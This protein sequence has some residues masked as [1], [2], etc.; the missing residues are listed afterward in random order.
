ML[1]PS[2]PAVSGDFGTVSS[3]QTD[4]LD[5]SSHLQY[6]TPASVNVWPW[7]SSSS[8]AQLETTSRMPSVWRRNYC[9]SN[10]KSADSNWFPQAVV[11]LRS[12]SMARISIPSCRRGTSPTTTP[13]SKP[14]ALT[15]DPRRFGRPISGIEFHHPIRQ[16]FAFRS[17]L[18]SAIGKGQSCAWRVMGAWWP[19]RSSKPLS[20]R[21]AG[22]GVFNSLPLRQLDLRFATCDFRFRAGFVSAGAGLNRQSSIANWKGGEPRVA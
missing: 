6:A 5:A 22:R 2:K 14:S 11:A 7:I 10:S 15:A 12:A 18:K 21:F 4:A 8:I 1:C 17:R 16:F 3:E 9:S 19:S 20:A 13:S